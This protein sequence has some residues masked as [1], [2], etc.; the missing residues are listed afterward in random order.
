MI[1]A[2]NKLTG[3]GMPKL[4]VLLKNQARLLSELSNIYGRTSGCNG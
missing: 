4:S 3:R 2:L 1:K